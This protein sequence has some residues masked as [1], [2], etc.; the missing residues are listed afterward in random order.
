LGACGR[1][2]KPRSSAQDIFRIIVIFGVL[3]LDVTSP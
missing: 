2:A 1:L 3:P